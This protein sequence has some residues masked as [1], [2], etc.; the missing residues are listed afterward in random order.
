[1]VGDRDRVLRLVELHL[2]LVRSVARRHARGGEALEELVQAGAVG[3]V[4]AARRFDPGR[5]VPFAAYALP[6]IEGEVRRHLRDRA[7][8]VRVPRREQERTRAFLRA[9]REV[10]QALGR[11]PSLTEAAA[12]AG[13][14]IEEAGRALG[15][16]A[17]SLSLDALDDRESRE[18]AEALEA[19]EQRTLVDELL[20]TL[21]PR[22]RAAVRL[23]YADDLPQR[24]IARRLHLSQSRTSRL[25][26]TSLDKLRRASRAA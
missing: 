24:E 16:T 20:A 25:L 3:L 22:E 21:T 14:S 4:A 19:C 7:S 18:A 5:R 13:L 12:A 15:G 8:T 6:T 17:A 1:M 10:A 9:E 2:P 23:R 11:A 26:S